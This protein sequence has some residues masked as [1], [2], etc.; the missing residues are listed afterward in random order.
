M[1]LSALLGTV[2]TTTGGS[3]G[4]Y[5]AAGN[6]LGTTTLGRTLGVDSVGPFNTTGGL[7]TVLNLTGPGVIGYAT[8]SGITTGS[9]SHRVVITIDGV[10]IVDS[11][12]TQSVTS[13]TPIQ[14]I[15]TSAAGIPI[16]YDTSLQIKYTSANGAAVSCNY[17]AIKT[18]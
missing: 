12:F 6:T 8:L 18:Q 11:T 1:K 7:T 4:V 3:F 14:N 16:R 17:Q 9:V 5:P 2:G 10:D 15:N 13:I